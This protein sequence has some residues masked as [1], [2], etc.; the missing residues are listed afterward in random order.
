MSVPGCQDLMLPFLELCSD[1]IER[2]GLVELS[3]QIAEKIGLTEADLDEK[4]ASGQPKIYNRTAWVKFY[5]GKA[6][7]LEFPSRSKFKIS[8]RGIDL[9]KSKPTEIRVN[10]L[11]QYPEFAQFRNGLSQ[12]SLENDTAVESANVGLQIETPDERLENSYQ[13]LRIQLASELLDI[14][15]K[16]PPS[17]FEQLV[18]DLL[19]AMGYGGSR[20]DAGEALGRPGDGGID[21][22][23]KEDKLGL[24]IICLQAK[25]YAID[26]VVPIKDVRDFT[27]SLDGRGAQKG[28]LITTSSF[29]EDGKDF[30]KKLQQKK[31]VLING[32]ELTQ[33][34]IDFNIGVSTT[35]TYAIKKIDLDYFE[36]D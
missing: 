23:I 27:G 6:G 9:L 15:L 34:M 26:N 35:A 3:K 29:T 8:Q 16:R 30:V 14:I 32:A 11:M 28:V 36:I 4:L 33:L 18:V 22:I 7:L 31:I 1:G 25:R 13:D 19:V 24:G 12:D 2:T 5:F 17:F 20:K 21:G 10:T